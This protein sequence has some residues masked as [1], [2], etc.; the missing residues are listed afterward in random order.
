VVLV[1]PPPLPHYTLDKLTDT[2]FFPILN[3]VRSVASSFT[4][5]PLLAEVKYETS[6]LFPFFPF[7]V[8]RKKRSD[9]FFFPPREIRYTGWNSFFPLGSST[10][11]LF[12]FLL[13]VQL[14]NPSPPPPP[15]F[16]LVADGWRDPF[17]PPVV[18]DFEKVHCFFSPTKGSTHTPSL[19]PMIY[20]IRGIGSVFAFFPFRRGGSTSLFFSYIHKRS[21]VPKSRI[22]PPFF[23]GRC[24]IT[25][26]FF[27]IPFLLARAGFLPAPRIFFATFA[28]L[29]PPF[30]INDEPR[31]LDPPPPPPPPSLP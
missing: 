9:F 13:E 26:T 10:S 19:S 11:A 15:F 1:S 25:P 14:D 12:S 24:V 8:V 3:I 2:F 6:K 16:L 21:A 30:S 28:A 18:N 7:L 29:P 22:G 4:S 23:F 17:P 20:A 31:L 5:S 27:L